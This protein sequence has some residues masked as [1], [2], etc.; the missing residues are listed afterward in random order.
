MNVSRLR[1]L[2]VVM[3]SLC[4]NHPAQA[5]DP[6]STLPPARTKG[7]QEFLPGQ[8]PQNRFVFQNMILSGK[9]GGKWKGSDL[10][11]ARQQAR[12]LRPANRLFAAQASG[13]ASTFAAPDATLLAGQSINAWKS[14]GPGDLGGRTRSLAIHPT[15]PL[16]MWLGSVGGGIWKTIDGGTT[17]APVDDFLPNLAIASL[18]VDPKRANVLYAGT[19][20]GYWN[21][22]GIRGE[23]IYRTTDGGTTWAILPSTASGFEYVNRLAIHPTNTA[24]LLA[25]TPNNLSESTDSG[26]TWTT[27][28]TRGVS[29]VAFQ[30]GNPSRAVA[31]GYG[32]MAYSNDG[33][34]T[35]T[36]VANLPTSTIGSG[37]IEIAFSP[38]LPSRVY[39]SLDHDGGM[40][41]RS[42]DGGMTWRK[43]GTS[44]TTLGGQG[45]YDNCIWV[46]PTNPNELMVGGTTGWISKDAG[47]TG[48]ALDY[49]YIH[50][51]W[52]KIT[53]APGWNGTT[54]RTVFVNTDGGIYRI[55]DWGT[56]SQVAQSLNN[57]LKIAQIYGNAGIDAT[58]W[59]VMGTQD[60]GTHV[61][62]G[63][64]ETWES[65]AGGDGGM[66][67]VDPTPDAN[68]YYYM[69]GE[70]QAGG[71]PFRHRR[72]PGSV[73]GTTEGIDRNFTDDFNWWA[74]LVLDTNGT[75]TGRQ[76]LF[77]G[78]TALYVLDNPRAASWPVNWRRIKASVGSNISTIVPV[79]GNPDK[80]WVGHNGGE[81]YRTTNGTSSTPTWTRMDLGKGLPSRMVTRLV[82]DPADPRTIYAS[83]S[84][85][86]PENLW[87]S[88]DEGAT[89]SP[90]PG[91]LPSATVYAVAVH[92]KNS[93]LI[94][95]A[96]EVGVFGSAD[97]GATWG[98]SATGP[99]NVSTY[100]ISFMGQKLLVG[101]HGRGSY[102]LDLGVPTLPAP[103]GLVALASLG[104]ASLSWN[105]VAT[106]TGYLVEMAT[107]SSGPWTEITRT[108][109]LTYVA[110]PLVQNG[111]YWFRVAAYNATTTGDRSG[112][113]SVYPFAPL[114]PTSVTA[115]AGDASVTLGW[116]PVAEATNYVVSRAAVAGGP[117]TAL[118]AVTS[119]GFTDLSVVNGTTY[120]YV[121]K[122]VNALG[123]SAA[124]AEVSATPRKVTAL[125]KALYKVGDAN[126]TDNT[127]QPLL[128][129]RNDGT[130]PVDLSKVTL[131]YWFTGDNTQP[132]SVYC[133]WAQ[134]GCASLATSVQAFSPSVPGADKFLEVGFAATAGQL[135]PGASTGAIQ[136]RLAHQNWSNFSES[137]DWSWVGTQ[138][139][140]AEALRVGVYVNGDLVSGQVPGVS[141]NPPTGLAALG[142]DAKVTLTWDAVAGA[143]AVRL[144]RKVAGGAYAAVG[145]STTTSFV[146]A[147]VV[148]GT[149][150]TY[151]ARSVKGASESSNS[152]EVIATPDRPRNPE[153]PTGVVAR[154]VDQGANVTWSPAAR[155][156][157]YDVKIGAGAAGPFTAARTG[158]TATSAQLTGLVNG[159][160][161]WVVVS[162]RNAIGES[163]N[164]V[165]DTVRPK[166]QPPVAPANLKAVAGNT[167]VSVS[168]DAVVG[169]TSY[170]LYKWTTTPSGKTVAYTGTTTGFVDRPLVN[171]TR[172]S[173]LATATNANGEGPSGDT[174]RATPRDS[175]AGFCANPR[176]LVGGSSGNFNTVNA[177]CLKVKSPVNG[178]GCSNFDGRTLKINGVTK[179]CGAAMGT[180]TADGWYWLD[181]GAGAYAWASIYWW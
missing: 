83:F 28:W 178:W 119:T 15:N 121:V 138:T 136:L 157:T 101:T 177:V 130:T 51:D 8:G 45:W 150:Y 88:K 118:P 144:Y 170:K 129:V 53:A 79:P 91:A 26:R 164:S 68:G 12:G 137:D 126:A 133:D 175:I 168:W 147:T 99:A 159:N 64:A 87:R 128:Q 171:G 65:V 113:A 180:A 163:P 152:I 17:W 179:T 103:T 22:D 174:V 132:V 50:P 9:A 49:W 1:T 62:T 165:P 60:N 46:N 122:A 66:C 73:T 166:G 139:T 108:T 106:A 41:L 47:A 25:A 33:G 176:E 84:G 146:D 169:A 81:I 52:H 86:N 6:A 58:D 115:T 134:I 107:S 21:I 75:A 85:F 156:L 123:S 54:N 7:A 114:V 125:V 16:I 63:D 167:Q 154:A 19:G 92:P 89:W 43:V 67:A 96:T 95:A 56:A 10:T 145:N 135:A 40:V 90:V 140:Y 142:G 127:I 3:A 160:L 37:R 18:A 61:Y 181:I 14:L 124:S 74:P 39:A 102:V 110:G 27:R 131:R 117:Y 2:V 112:S 149:T 94:Y 76:R 32:A 44:S 4:A 148:N 141:L 173:Y 48:T 155:A 105:A 20:E 59:V 57:G 120:H 104:S 13:A 98:T 35:W 23:G 116:S 69:Y 93:N 80:I 11:R 31:S 109:A 30:P 153:A 97:G 172:Y 100:D 34:T 77:Q 111:R 5:A 151:T 82:L 42:D 24:R 162:A 158:L 72:A 161:Y 143:D 70:Y 55:D 78:G 71:G 29:D 36:E 38:S